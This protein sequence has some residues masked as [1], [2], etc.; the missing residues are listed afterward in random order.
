MLLSN[1]ADPNIKTRNAEGNS[2]LHLA[3]DQ[4]NVAVAKA[5]VAAG[6]DVN[7]LNGQGCTP[8]ELIMCR[9][10]NEA[11]GEL[12]SILGISPP[13][14]N[15]TTPGTTG[16]MQ[17]PPGQGSTVGGANSMVMPASPLRGGMSPR[18]QTPLRQA[19][20][21]ISLAGD[22]GGG[23]H[24]ALLREALSSLT[25]KE[26]YALAVAVN[27]SESTEKKTR[28]SGSIASSTG[29]DVASASPNMI[30]SATFTVGISSAAAASADAASDNFSLRSRS[31][32]MNNAEG[33]T[34]NKGGDS[35]MKNME[36]ATHGME[37]EEPPHVV[38]EDDV[39]RVVTENHSSVLAAMGPINRA[40]QAQ[41]D[42]DARKIQSNVRAWI[43]R[44]QYK[45]IREAT[46]KVQALAKGHLARRH[47]RELRE[48][49]S[50]TLV[51]QKS[52]RA[53]IK[54][55]RAKSAATTM[56]ASNPDDAV[57]EDLSKSGMPPPQT[58]AAPPPQQQ[59]PSWSSAVL[60]ERRISTATAATTGGGG[61][62]Q[63]HPDPAQTAADDFLLSSDDLFDV[64]MRDD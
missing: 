18:P 57:I 14:P 12:F 31:G 33:N 44:R 40:E 46:K 2:A 52:L 41:L 42:A 5:L 34:K 19:S 16:G 30:G 8:A 47:F 4:G 60:N 63:Q 27:N 26:Q 48:K 43:L 37:Q 3:C 49:V 53:H 50:A 58:T 6:A 1:G 62:G 23:S 24:M 29:Y 51:I 32:T 36:S 20:G 9:E 22:N 21:S 10:E 28:R 7:L 56:L 13:G 17:S 54:S 45:E 55:K 59:Q 11:D 38:E 25:L 39:A 15:S 64:N 61:E 35:V